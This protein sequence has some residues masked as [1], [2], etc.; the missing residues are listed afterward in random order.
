MQRLAD[1]KR[2]PVDV[3][4]LWFCIGRIIACMHQPG[5]T[6]RSGFEQAGCVEGGQF[7]SPARRYFRPRLEP[8]LQGSRVDDVTSATRCPTDHEAVYET[9]S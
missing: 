7:G 8:A 9:R 6:E 3:I 2:S 5:S 1:V 4:E